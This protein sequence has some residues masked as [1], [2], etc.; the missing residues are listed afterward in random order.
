MLGVQS[1]IFNLAILFLIKP[2]SVNS[3]QKLG[4]CISLF[5]E[6][7]VKNSDLYFSRLIW[8]TS[9]NICVFEIDKIFNSYSP[10]KNEIRGDFG[11][12]VLLIPLKCKKLLESDLK[13][14][15]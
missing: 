9:W 3:F 2:R 11:I 5:D 10:L 8:I 1:Q 13:S 6:K 4:F 15:V 7:N 12:N 14:R